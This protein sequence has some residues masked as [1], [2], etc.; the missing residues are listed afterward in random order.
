MPTPGPDGEAA[1][2]G[3]P[4]GRGHRRPDADGPREVPHAHRQPQLRGR[5]REGQPA[6]GHHP[7]RLRGRREG[8]RAG[9]RARRSKTSSSWRAERGQFVPNVTTATRGGRLERAGADDPLAASSTRRGSSRRPPTTSTRRPSSSSS[10]TATSSAA[11]PTTRASASGLREIAQCNG[12]AACVQRVARQHVGRLLPLHRVS[13]DG[14]HALP[15]QQGFVRH[16]AAPQRLPREDAGG[17]AGRRRRAAGL[18]GEARGEQGGGGRGVG[19]ARR[20]PA[21]LRLALERAVRGRALRRTRAS[22]RPTPSAP[23]SSR[24]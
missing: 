10:S 11:R 16:D 14:L 4:R 1:H 9:H 12:D 24:A 3:A 6:R 18:A 19:G 21:A 22:S 17:G 2:R 7:Q 13:G 23:R 5:G 15:L 8:R 20:L